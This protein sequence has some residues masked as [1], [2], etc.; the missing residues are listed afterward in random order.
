[1]KFINILKYLIIIYLLIIYKNVHKPNIIILNWEK[2]SYDYL[3][4]KFQ[5]SDSQN[6]YNDSFKIINESTNDIF[7]LKKVVY[8]VILANYDEIKEINIQK[9]YDY[10]LFSDNNSFFKTN[11]TILPIP[12][13]VKN[14]NINKVK[15]Q[16]YL[17]LHPHLYF[18]NYDLSIYIDA[19]MGIKGDLNEF[20]IRT[21]SSKY[22]I[23]TFEHPFRNNIF[24][25]TLEVARVQKERK[26]ISER[27]RKRYRIENFTDKTGLVETCL[28]IR[29]H[30]IQNCIN[31]MNNWFEEIQNYS[32]R[33]QLSFNYVIWKTKSKIKY[34]VK[35]FA[36]EYFNQTQ[37][38]K[39][40]FNLSDIN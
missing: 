1:M 18:K 29:N 13:E 19:T 38:H 5:N 31:L 40:I 27:V 15:K 2:I 8:S 12:E 23:Y 30:N 11:W 28:I 36:L 21:L 20:L 9:G 37:V 4:K 6:N 10:F 32:H 17:K 7:K 3:F 24:D 34:I 25:E 35:N 39:Q 33:D 26:E 22:Y 16:R 14:L